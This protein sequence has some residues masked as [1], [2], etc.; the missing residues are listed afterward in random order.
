MIKT[1]PDKLPDW[2]TDRFD[3]VLWHADRDLPEVYLTFDDGPTP[4]VTDEVLNILGDHHALA[5]FFCLGKNVIQHPEL[6]SRILAE[7]HSVGNHTQNHLDGWKTSRASYVN[8]ALEAANSIDSKLFRPP[9]GHIRPSQLSSLRELGCRLVMWDVLAGDFA[10]RSPESIL[11]NLKKN[12]RGGS[13]IVFHDSEK[14]SSRI[15]SILP[16][17]LQFLKEEGMNPRPIR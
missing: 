10:D 14:A 4:G 8:D 3:N 15:L 6:Y 1:Y 16:E 13:I 7:G 2:L 11:A 17:F 12:V 9:Y 5:T